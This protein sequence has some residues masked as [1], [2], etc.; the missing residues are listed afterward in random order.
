GFNASANGEVFAVTASSSTV[1]FGGNFSSA[2]GSSRPGRAAAVNATTGALTAWAPVLANGR[3]YGMEVSPDGSKVVI[4]GSFTTLNGS[5]NP[6]Y[7]LGAVNATS[8]ASLAMPAN[9]IIRNAG[10]NSAV[11]GMNCDSDS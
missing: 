10:A 8:G 6:G 3:A 2:N 5:G 9:A 7:G 11:F 1:F 4:G